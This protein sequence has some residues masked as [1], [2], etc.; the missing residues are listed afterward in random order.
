MEFFDLI[1]PFLPM[2]PYHLNRAFPYKHRSLRLLKR[3]RA[4]SFVNL[5]GLGG[6]NLPIYFRVFL[7]TTKTFFL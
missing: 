6:Q 4:M 3:N 1:P 2:K 7:D 5:N